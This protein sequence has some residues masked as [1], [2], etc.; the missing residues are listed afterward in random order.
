MENYKC[1]STMK[2]K[3]RICSFKQ[4]SKKDQYFLIDYLRYT[5]Y[6]PTKKLLRWPP[7][8]PQCLAPGEC[9]YRAQWGQCPLQSRRAHPACGLDAAAFHAPS[10]QVAAI[11]LSKGKEQVGLETDCDTWSNSNRKACI[12][13]LWEWREKK[14]KVA[15]AEDRGI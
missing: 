7:R 6:I 2:Y 15:H 11:L 12:T 14:I 4:L 8:L 3:T 5:R 1:L 13:R 9:L 10:P